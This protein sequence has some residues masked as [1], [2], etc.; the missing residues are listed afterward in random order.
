MK[1]ESE[2]IVISDWKEALKILLHAW[3]SDHR[4]TCILYI[5][6]LLPHCYSYCRWVSVLFYVLKKPP[7]QQHCRLT[8]EGRSPDTSHTNKHTQRINCSCTWSSIL[9]WRRGGTTQPRKWPPSTN[10]REERTNFGMGLDHSLSSACGKMRE[11]AT[12]ATMKWNEKEFV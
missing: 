2:V 5:L 4:G 3:E 6:H 11:N 8:T 7:Y 12:T 1:R 10:D 9:I